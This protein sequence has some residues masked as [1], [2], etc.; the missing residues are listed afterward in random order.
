ML[1]SGLGAESI[2]ETLRSDLVEAGQTIFDRESRDRGPS[3]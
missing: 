2:A 3:D 1:G